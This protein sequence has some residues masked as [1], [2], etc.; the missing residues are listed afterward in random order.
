MSPWTLPLVVLPLLVPLAPARGADP[1]QGKEKNAIYAM[2][3]L[4]AG[5]L[6]RLLFTKEELAIFSEGLKDGF[7]GA[8]KLKPG[9]H[10]AN[11]RELRDTRNKAVAAAERKASQAF[12][13]QAAR[14]RGAVVTDSGLIYVSI[15]DGLGERPTVL[16]KVTVHYHGTLRDGTVFDS[17]RE[18]GEPAS[19]ALNRVIPCWT[20]GL[21]KMK[22][23]GKAKLVCPT[24]IAYADRGAGQLIK[25]G[26]ALVF[27]VELI[28]IEGR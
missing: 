12:V 16:D 4:Q 2:G 3:V 22:V 1:Y 14:E 8:P 9:A 28:S 7:A 15:S 23:G 10:A 20:E 11:L 27:E 21:Q 18:R 24:E 19:F 25:P 13:A 26:A 6:K 17:S 5:Q